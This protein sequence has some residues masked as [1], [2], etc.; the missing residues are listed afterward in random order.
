[1]A[2]KSEKMAKKGKNK[3]NKI[4]NLKIPKTEQAFSFQME[5]AKSVNKSIKYGVGSPETYSWCRFPNGNWVIINNIEVL[6]MAILANAG[7]ERVYETG[8]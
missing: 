3:Y 2:K 7:I 1:M 5:T 4:N 8:K 6:W